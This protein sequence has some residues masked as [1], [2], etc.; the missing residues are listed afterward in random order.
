LYETLQTGEADRE[1]ESVA[2]WQA[3]YDLATG[4]VLALKVRTES[5]N[6]MLALAKR[7]MNFTNPR[8]N[9]WVLVAA[10]QIDVGSQWEKLADKARM[11]LNRVVHDHPG[12]PWALL[13]ARELEEPIGWRWVEAHTPMEPEPASDQGAN[14]PPRPRDEQ[15]VRL[16]RPKPTRPVPKL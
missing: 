4:C 16:E 13:A 14:T 6:A 11:Y 8:S 5:Y 3:G 7:G 10:D 12:T 2:R 1:R 9:T 15:P